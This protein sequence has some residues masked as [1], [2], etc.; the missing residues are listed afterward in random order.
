M[1]T[2]LFLYSVTPAWLRH[3]RAERNALRQTHLQPL[4][5]RHADHVQARF[6]DAEAFG[7]RCTDFV[8]FET[9]SLPAYYAL[10]EALRDT[11]LFTTPYLT[12]N[13]IIIGIND[14]FAHFENGTLTM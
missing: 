12:V 8:I 2:I 11:P 4:L 1:Y 7:G 14:G 10:I 3:T 5:E 6:C 13:D 9:A